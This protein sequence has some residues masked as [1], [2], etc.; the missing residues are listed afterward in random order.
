MI[1][2]PDRN[3]KKCVLVVYLLKQ[4]IQNYK[5]QDVIIFT[6]FIQFWTFQID[7]MVNVDKNPPKKGQILKKKK[8]YNEAWLILVGGTDI[9]MQRFKSGCIF[10]LL[11]HNPLDFVSEVDL[12]T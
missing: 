4:N 6:L 12:V 3:F 10:I 2:L 11:E 8:A 1:I 5:I 7:I 9:E